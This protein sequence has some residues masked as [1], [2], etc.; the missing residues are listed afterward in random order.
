MKIPY[1]SDALTRLG[2]S[3]MLTNG[4][5]HTLTNILSYNCYGFAGPGAAKGLPPGLLK[6]SGLPAQHFHALVAAQVDLGGAGEDAV[7]H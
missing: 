2:H 4:V 3:D 6:K 1:E 5:L 7:L